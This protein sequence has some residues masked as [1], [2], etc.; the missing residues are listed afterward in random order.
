VILNT[1]TNYYIDSFENYSASAI[2]A[3]AVFRSVIGGI[4][5]LFAPAMFKSLGYGWGISVF[6]FL[7]L[8]MAPAPVLFYYTG[9]WLRS[10]FQIK[11]D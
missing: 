7:A 4:V 11:L 3:G 5:P 1:T 6:G 10:R 8:A 9:P 2:A